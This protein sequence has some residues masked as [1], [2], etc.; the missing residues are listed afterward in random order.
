MRV[1]EKEEIITDANDV[2]WRPLSSWSFDESTGKEFAVPE[3][4]ER[5]Y[6][7]VSEVPVRNIFSHWSTGFGCAN[8][9][10]VIVLGRKHTN[11]NVIGMLEKNRAW[12]WEDA[13]WKWK[14]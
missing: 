7:F 3:E 2:R 11:I 10:E 5:G 14:G 9:H 8:E 12:M 1:D 4:G 13:K 6:L